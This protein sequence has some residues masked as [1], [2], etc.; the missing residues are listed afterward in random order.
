MTLSNS[1]LNEQVKT[2]NSQLKLKINQLEE[3]KMILTREKNAIERKMSSILTE[4]QTNA[5]HSNN[6][7]ISTMRRECQEELNN[8][9]IYISNISI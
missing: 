4:S 5:S 1:N 9:G 2:D 3:E 6:M 7:A 8:K